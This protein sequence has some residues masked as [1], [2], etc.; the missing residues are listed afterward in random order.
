MKTAYC[1]LRTRKSFKVEA[2]VPKWGNGDPQ[3]DPLSLAKQQSYIITYLIATVRNHSYE[4]RI[5]LSINMFSNT[6]K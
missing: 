2:Q 1:C 5:D 4:P 6:E 3:S